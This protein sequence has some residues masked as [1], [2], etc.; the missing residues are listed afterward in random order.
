MD[1]ATAAI[2]AKDDVQHEQNSSS[3]N[4]LVLDNVLDEFKRIYEK[5]AREYKGELSR[6][7]GKD[8]I[9]ALEVVEGKADIRESSKSFESAIGGVFAAIK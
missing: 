4:D 2:E 5:F 7:E 9:N 6:I 8:I 1:D 3:M